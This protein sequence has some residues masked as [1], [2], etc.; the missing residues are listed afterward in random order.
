MDISLN[1]CFYK[2]LFWWPGQESNERNNI[3]VISRISKRHSHDTPKDTP[4]TWDLLLIA[5]LTIKAKSPGVI[6][7]G[8]SHSINEGFQV[9]T[10]EH[11]HL[12]LTPRNQSRQLHAAA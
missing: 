4:T 5:N 12:S 6:P 7:R 3:F 1:P 10:N 9:L 2:M 8:F 11:L